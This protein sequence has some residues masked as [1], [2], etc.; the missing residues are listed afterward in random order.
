MGTRCR[1]EL[2]LP[3]FNFSSVQE[4]QVL[5]TSVAFE[6]YLERF[7]GLR[8]E[9]VEGTVIQMLPAS[10]EIECACAPATPGT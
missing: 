6:D 8:C 7:S 1:E 10:L 2:P 9:L 3:K 5:A 4:V